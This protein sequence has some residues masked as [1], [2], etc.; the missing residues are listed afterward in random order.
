MS[1]EIKKPRNTDLGLERS[2]EAFS[3]TVEFKLRGR[4]T[5]TW[6]LLGKL[7]PTQEIAIA[8]AGTY[9][10]LDWPVWRTG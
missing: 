8:L 6:K 10:A 2:K 4:G 7:V 5:V 3:E 9:A 1:S